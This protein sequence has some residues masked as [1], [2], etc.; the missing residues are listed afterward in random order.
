MPV[1]YRSAD[2]DSGRWLG[3]PFR[4]GDIVISTRSKS[5]T[6]WLQMIAA[7]L[8]FQTPDLPRPLSE[9]SPWLD[10]L[11][12][13]EGRGVRATRGP[14]PSPVHQDPHTAGRDAARQ[15][16]HLHRGRPAPAGHG[17]VAL[18]PGRQPRPGA[19]PRADR[20]AGEPANRPRPTALHEW[21]S[22]WIDSDGE[23]R[24][25]LDS[26]PGVM[27]HL[28]DAWARRRTSRNVVLV[29]LRRHLVAR[30]RRGDAKARGA[31]RDLGARGQPG[32][33]SSRRRRSTACAPSRSDRSQPVIRA[34]GRAG[35]LPE[36][37]VGSGARGAHRRELARYHAR[38]SHSHRPNCWPGCTAE[39]SR[40]RRTFAASR[41]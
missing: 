21:M 19:H 32:P 17:G 12:H 7:L 25:Q 35:L 34:Q 13:P 5:G 40:L 38:T 18:S 10:W 36:G 16:G 2:E 29:A 23:P 9:L 37:H 30:P 15:A 6:T 33:T 14:A 27:W 3:F 11:D 8:V 4:D 26:L 31:A 41:R 24:Q 39:M 28:S 22:S 20:P 1:R